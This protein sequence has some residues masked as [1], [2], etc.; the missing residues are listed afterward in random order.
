MSPKYSPY[1]RSVI[2]YLN[3]EHPG[4]A[5]NPYSGLPIEGPNNT[6]IYNGLR[7]TSRQFYY[8][9]GLYSLPQYINRRLGQIAGITDP[10]K[11]GSSLKGF[12]RE[13]KDLTLKMPSISSLT[14][15]A[16]RYAFSSSV[17]D[18][19]WAQKMAN[20]PFPSMEQ[21]E[22]WANEIISRGGGTSGVG[23]KAGQYI[24][25][26]KNLM[27]IYPG[28]GTQEEVRKYAT[29]LDFLPIGQESGPGIGT[30]SSASWTPRGIEVAEG[31]VDEMLTGARPGYTSSIP[32]SNFRAG[33]YNTSLVRMAEYATPGAGGD[34]TQVAALAGDAFAIRPNA[35]SGYY[36]YRPKT[37]A[38]NPSDVSKGF[39]DKLI[40]GASIDNDVINAIRSASLEKDADFKALIAE[41]YTPREA[42]RHLGKTAP[43]TDNIALSLVKEGKNLRL[44]YGEREA[45]GVGAKLSIELRKG[46]AAHSPSAFKGTAA[47]TD[48]VLAPLAKG[49]EARTM[50]P[51]YQ[52]AEIYLT[53]PQFVSPK[54]RLVN[55]QRLAN[56]LNRENRAMGSDSM[57]RALNGTLL[58]PDNF[59][60]K[61]GHVRRAAGLLPSQYGATVTALLEGVN[62][63]GV[64]HPVYVQ[65]LDQ[66]NL[67]KEG[68][69]IKA[70][71]QDLMGLKQAGMTVQE[72]LI[73]EKIAST[74]E[75][76]E[77]RNILKYLQSKTPVPGAETLTSDLQAAIAKNIT[78]SGGAFQGHSGNIL[79]D[80]ELDKQLSTA[81]TK[82]GLSSGVQGGRNK[83]WML[84]LGSTFD[85]TLGEG[86]T[87]SYSQLP[88]LS[89]DLS[90]MYATPGGKTWASEV[91]KAK[92]GVI[93]ATASGDRT[94]I[95]LAGQRYLNEFAGLSGKN[96]LMENM[97]LKTRLKGTRTT[98]GF[99][100]A[101]QEAIIRR[102]ISAVDP[103][104]KG[105]LGGF[106]VVSLKKAKQIMHQAT[107]KRN[108]GFVKKTLEQSGGFYSTQMRPP[109]APAGWTSSRMWLMNPEI[110]AAGHYGKKIDE[111]LSQGS[112]SIIHG[113]LDADPRN[114]VSEFM[115]RADVQQEL[116]ET[117]YRKQSAFKEAEDAAIQKLIRTDTPINLAAVESKTPFEVAMTNILKG[118]NTGVTHNAAFKVFAGAMMKGTDPSNILRG[119]FTQEYSTNLS[120]VLFGLAEE[121]INA[122]R[123]LQGSAQFVNMSEIL[124][125][126]DPTKK[127]MK[128]MDL[129]T[130]D[131]MKMFGP[132]ARKSVI[133][134]DILESLTAGQNSITAAMQK[135][136]SVGGPASIAQLFEAF[137]P[138]ETSF[139]QGS[140]EGAFHKAGVFESAARQSA[141]NRTY[142]DAAKSTGQEIGGAVRE[143]VG[144]YVSGLRQGRGWTSLAIGGAVLAGVGMSMRKPGNITVV[145]NAQRSGEQKDDSGRYVKT[146]EPDPVVAA[147]SQRSVRL[148]PEKS[149]DVRVKIKEAQR[150]HNSKFVD[151]AD[152]LSSK[153]KRPAKASIN[154]RDDSSEQNYAKIFRD[155]YHRQLRLGT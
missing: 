154:I 33:A 143:A 19:S 117:W 118:R 128:L 72:R 22:E 74:S 26:G 150:E 27:G 96:K 62:L 85:F 89:Q 147:R 91:N 110:T 105:D 92:L 80:P 60:I 29:I 28:L 57:V 38:F 21:H 50:V 65:A 10:S 133:A 94:A 47:T 75:G 46:L 134:R 35:L 113:D 23:S 88:L 78:I 31:I 7:R 18:I 30:T 87:R 120:N 111:L 49:S 82:M 132:N 153:Y 8:E 6:V 54:K 14:G 39:L 53:D 148:M 97:V 126:S 108:L 123:N 119:K 17:E 139:P 59:G 149:Y 67:N 109:G 2:D 101:E 103:T 69:F 43:G 129:L 64:A 86:V 137:L 145:S 155:E 146:N 130:P 71:V 114:T 52:A 102:Q 135:T 70:G 84:P 24:Y 68:P 56:A 152:A 37:I 45:L 79:F 107:G 144:S 32:G 83:T 138:G 127:A 63:K 44:N 3:K 11:R 106:H 58:F 104:F 131:H 141:Q 121:Q 1:D 34:L 25:S 124:Y 73:A 5:V 42:L 125:G 99:L 98:M 61:A 51:L 140:V 77:F 116:K 81:L 48:I 20:V 15:R 151:L 4:L 9:G 40:H 13:A 100:N 36:S 55:A 136:T 16:G 115:G 66:T 90:A 122:K 41:G 112:G 76:Q 142:A 12:L 93:K 95:Q